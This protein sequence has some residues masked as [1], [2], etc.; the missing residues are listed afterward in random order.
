VDK[1]LIHQPT[2]LERM[3]M[4][5][6]EKKKPKL[7]EYSFIVPSFVLAEKIDHTMIPSFGNY[8]NESQTEFKQYHEE[9]MA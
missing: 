9:Q 1:A 7:A 5:V 6:K 4:S 3:R 8:N 2:I